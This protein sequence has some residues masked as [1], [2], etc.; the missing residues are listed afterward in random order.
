[1]RLFSHADVTSK[2]TPGKHA[3]S[4]QHQRQAAAFGFRAATPA[5]SA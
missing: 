1:M 3:R 2:G 4:L 5:A